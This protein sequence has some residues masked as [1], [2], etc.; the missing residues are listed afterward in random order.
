LRVSLGLHGVLAFGDTNTIFTRGNRHG[1]TYQPAK[2]HGYFHA[3][4]ER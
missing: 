1:N 2:R 3:E 4:R